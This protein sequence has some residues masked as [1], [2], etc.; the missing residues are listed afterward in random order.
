MATCHGSP[1]RSS[2]CMSATSPCSSARTLASPARPAPTRCGSSRRRSIFANLALQ[3]KPPRCGSCRRQ[4]L[5]L[6]VAMLACPWYIFPRRCSSTSYHRSVLLGLAVSPTEP[7]LNM[8]QLEAKARHHKTACKQDCGKTSICSGRQ[9]KPRR[10][11]LSDRHALN[12]ANSRKPD[13]DRAASVRGW[14]L[15]AG[16]WDLELE[17]SDPRCTKIKQILYA[18]LMMGSCCEHP[19]SE[20]LVIANRRNHDASQAYDIAEEQDDVLQED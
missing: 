17:R 15:E 11:L 3:S 20:L 4:S 16:A 6:P 14:D 7:A 12:L 13:T 10:P 1:W 9:L 19:I 8:L 2:G 5:V 18:V